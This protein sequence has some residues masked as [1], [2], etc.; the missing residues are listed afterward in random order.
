MTRVI[1][2]SLFVAIILATFVQADVLPKE[3]DQ[4]APVS[5]TRPYQDSQFGPRKLFSSK[6]SVTREPRRFQVLEDDEDFERYQ[7]GEPHPVLS[8]LFD[9]DPDDSLEK[10]SIIAVEDPLINEEEDIDRDDEKSSKN[11]SLD[12]LTASTGKQEE[13][14]TVP[15]DSPLQE[16]DSSSAEE[17]STT[18]INTA[19]HTPELANP[20]P[21]TP[22]PIAIPENKS[23]D[24]PDKKDAE[25]LSNNQLLDSPPAP[26]EKHEES[27]AVTAD[28]PSQEPDSS[29][30]EESSTT[31]IN[32][33]DH[34]PE[35]ANPDPTT[36]VQIATP[37]NNSTDPP[38]EK[39]GESS[40]KS[41]SI[42]D[43]TTSS[44][45]YKE[46]LAFPTDSTQQKAD[47]SLT[48]EPS[49]T[50]TTI[51]VFTSDLAYP[52]PTTPMPSQIEPQKGESIDSPLREHAEMFNT[53]QHNDPI[54]PAPIRIETTE[55]DVNSVHDGSA[56][57][58]RVPIPSSFIFVD[59]I[60]SVMDLSELSASYI[61]TS[62]CI[63]IACVL[64]LKFG[65]I[66]T[67]YDRLPSSDEAKMTAKTKNEIFAIRSQTDEMRKN[68]G[69]ET[70]LTVTNIDSLKNYNKML[71]RKLEYRKKLAPIKY[72]LNSL[73]STLGS[74]I[75]SLISTRQRY[76]ECLKN[77]KSMK[78][79]IIE[80][81]TNVRLSKYEQLLMIRNFVKLEDLLD[82]IKDIEFNKQTKSLRESTFEMKVESQFLKEQ[83]DTF[84]QLTDSFIEQYQQLTKEIA[85][86]KVK[87]TE[88]DRIYSELKEIYSEIDLD[89]TI[90]DLKKRVDAK[91][92]EADKYYRNY[93]GNYYYR[94]VNNA[95]EVE[96][97]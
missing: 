42:D 91:V 52:S 10:D 80:Y 50:L 13:P 40:S 75:G 46:P 83:V 84:R 21:T 2:I 37:E 66:A 1:Y 12:D 81:Q 33:A 8:A 16:P 30:V 44:E 73:R 49:T 58:T 32:T 90:D 96:V 71:E 11:Q 4:P 14:V 68:L 41:R 31:Y 86:E 85:D 67:T 64:L 53:D 3:Q 6:R 63:S 56:H 59:A 23:T 70:D 60:I 87:S 97:S 22:V 65:K 18:Y 34:T 43:Q 61:F 27:V 82:L 28:F 47:S 76:L 19:D 94:A 89:A 39:D 95:Q 26:S 7:M 24:L 25:I 5:T 74:D 38:L 77:Y 15:T 48:E 20:D 72:K 17:S 92:L 36:P 9:E 69:L 78:D 93:I 57:T 29:S 62:L 51:S 54:T 79:R 55:Y 35:L 88:N 45:K